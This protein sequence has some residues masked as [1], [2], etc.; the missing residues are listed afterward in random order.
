MPPKERDTYSEVRDRKLLDIRAQLGE[1]TQEYVI[2]A[3]F[4]ENGKQ[5]WRTWSDDMWA[6]GAM[7]R[8]T[9]DL[10]ERI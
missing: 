9:D 4:N 2:I 8:L 3:K 5:L 10:R 1:I 7:T 6:L